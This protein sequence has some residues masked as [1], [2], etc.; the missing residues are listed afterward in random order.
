MADL[1]LDDF[2]TIAEKDPEAALLLLGA[3]VHEK[4]GLGSQED[5]VRVFVQLAS[6]GVNVPRLMRDHPAV[7]R[8][9]FGEDL[10]R[11]SEAMV[12]QIDRL[13]GR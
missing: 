5:V 12:E 1:E 11:P 4:N 9:A 6:D 2:P 10:P 3:Y 7:A 8:D 13:A